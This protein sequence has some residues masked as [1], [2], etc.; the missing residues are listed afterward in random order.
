MVYSVQ[1]RI[2]IENLYKFK[3]CGAKKLIRKFPG[4]G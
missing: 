4:K 3:N 2:S 1:D